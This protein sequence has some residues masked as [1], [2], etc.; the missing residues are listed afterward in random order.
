MK[1]KKKKEHEAKKK[2][3]S[4]NGQKGHHKRSQQIAD[5][6][7]HHGKSSASLEAG[8]EASSLSSAL[9]QMHASSTARRDWRKRW[10]MPSAAALGDMETNSTQAQ[11]ATLRRLGEA[12]QSSSVGAS[13]ELGF[14]AEV[15][16]LMRRSV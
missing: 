7:T 2:S 6:N 11:G 10:Y 1:D 4:I 5:G 3:G 9:S 13:G 14:H 8:D 12:N 16:K 15:H